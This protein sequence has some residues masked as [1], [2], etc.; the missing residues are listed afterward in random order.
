MDV[1]RLALSGSFARSLLRV[2]ARLR[3]AIVEGLQQHCGWIRVAGL[4]LDERVLHVAAIEAVGTSLED[5]ALSKG[6][7]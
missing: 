4:S 1:Q 6:P 2:A 5:L 3:L 7:Q